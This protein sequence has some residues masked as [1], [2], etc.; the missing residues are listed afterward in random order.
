MIKD[1]SKKKC[2]HLVS[3]NQRFE[4]CSLYIVCV[5]LYYGFLCTKRENMT[6]QCPNNYEIQQNKDRN[7]YVCTLQF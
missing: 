6:L 1:S 2:R 4:D 7:T 5:F 3:V